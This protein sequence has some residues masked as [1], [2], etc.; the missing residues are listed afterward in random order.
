M[1]IYKIF[2][3][4]DVKLNLYATVRQ[5]ATQKIFIYKT[6]KTVCFVNTNDYLTKS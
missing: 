4:L 5:S 3:Y 6:D 2:V 1:Y